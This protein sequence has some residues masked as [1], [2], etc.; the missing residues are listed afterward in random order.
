MEFVRLEP[1]NAIPMMKITPDQTAEIIREA[2]KP[3][4]LRQG[5]GKWSYIYYVT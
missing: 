2:D 5:S 4:N 3:P 1:F